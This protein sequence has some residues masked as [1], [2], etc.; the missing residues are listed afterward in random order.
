MQNSAS[1]DLKAIL[2][3]LAFWLYVGMPLAWGIWSTVKKAAALF[4]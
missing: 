4:N 2:I 3:L 1:A